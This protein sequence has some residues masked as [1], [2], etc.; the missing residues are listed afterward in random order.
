[1]EQK[2][3]QVLAKIVFPSFKQNTGSTSRFHSHQ[4]DTV[5][6]M[7]LQR[8]SMWVHFHFSAEIMN[9]KA[10]T[11]VRFGTLFRL[12]GFL[13]AETKMSIKP[14][15]FQHLMSLKSK[16]KSM[17]KMI[18]RNSYHGFVKMS[19]KSRSFEGC[20]NIFCTGDSFPMF[21]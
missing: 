13:D 5:F 7:D 1:M 4:K 2:G 15:S 10:S 12:I 8:A 18:A 11:A 14:T 6:L 20:Q 19:L 17:D 9:P 21:F 16:M 3:L